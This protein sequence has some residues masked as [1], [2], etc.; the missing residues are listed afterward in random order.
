MPTLASFSMPQFLTTN[1]HHSH[2]NGD[3]AG[4]IFKLVTDFSLTDLSLTNYLLSQSPGGTGR[5]GGE[6]WIGAGNMKGILSC[7][8]QLAAATARTIIC[9]S[10]EDF[11]IT[12]VRRIY[13]YV[14]V[15]IQNII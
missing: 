15:I 6:E 5:G 13:L 1:I 7:G 3:F 9:S 2:T 10:V 12:N 8:S 11:V 4:F 14:Q